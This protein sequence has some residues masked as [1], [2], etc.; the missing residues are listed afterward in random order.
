MHSVAV[1][2][3]QRQQAHSLVAPAIA[4]H[5]CTWC[6]LCLGGA[7]ATVTSTPTRR[8]CRARP[9]TMTSATKRGASPDDAQ[10]MT[11]GKPAE[12]NSD[13]A[14][15]FCATF[16]QQPQ[17]ILQGSLDVDSRQGRRSSACAPRSL[18]TAW[19]RDG[20]LRCR[21]LPFF[22]RTGL[23]LHVHQFSRCRVIWHPARHIRPAG[24]QLRPARLP[25]HAAGGLLPRSRAFKAHGARLQASARRAAPASTP[26]LATPGQ[27]LQPAAPVQ[28]RL[29]RPG[30]AL[31]LRWPSLLLAS[32]TACCGHAAACG[33]AAASSLL[34]AGLCC[35]GVA[36]AEGDQLLTERVLLAGT[37]AES[38]GVALVGGQPIL[39]R[40]S[41]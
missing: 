26:G 14:P 19:L 16:F 37:R 32:G 28:R 39:G 9:S 24:R 17:H 11:S 7:S 35:R 25:S 15:Q 21:A 30:R 12:A 18:A 38:L 36:C 1:S 8:S 27:H 2:N 33:L 34:R 31:W 13:A 10:G 40:R 41:V 23:R 4:A 20:A 22:R 3:Q 29:L 6:R 5:L